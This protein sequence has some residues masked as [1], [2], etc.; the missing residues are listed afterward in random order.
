MKLRILLVIGIA[1]TGI[2]VITPPVCVG[3]NPDRLEPELF[4][5]IETF[6][7]WYE[8]VSVTVFGDCDDM[9]EAYAKQAAKDGWLI[10]YQFCDANGR[11]NNKQVMDYGTENHMGLLIMTYDKIYWIDPMGR[12]KPVFIGKR[13]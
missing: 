10:A 12:N 1:L 9:A 8:N 7:S 11:M 4:P 5:D 13:D 2:L 6:N 3:T